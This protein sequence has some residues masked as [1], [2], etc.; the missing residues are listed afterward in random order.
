M[1]TFDMFVNDSHFRLAR[2]EPAPRATFAVGKTD[3]SM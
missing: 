1:M 2:L 3:F